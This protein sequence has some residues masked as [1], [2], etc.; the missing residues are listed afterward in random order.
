MKADSFFFFPLLLV[1][2]F[3]HNIKSR[4]KGKFLKFSFH[5]RKKKFLFLSFSL[6]NFSRKWIKK[7][8]PFFPKFPKSKIDEKKIFL[9]FR[10]FYQN[11]KKNIEYR[12]KKKI[13][14]E[15]KKKTFSFPSF[16]FSKIIVDLKISKLARLH[17]V[18]FTEA[19]R[20]NRIREPMV[21]GW[22]NQRATIPSKWRE[23]LSV[24]RSVTKCQ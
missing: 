15:E 3:F 24:P 21:H 17:S 10:N 4:L 7:K 1:Q 18:R 8:F 23:K 6:W 11:E 19:A 22:G 9:F 16:R 13:S 20:R 12:Q 5:R 2:P 14:I